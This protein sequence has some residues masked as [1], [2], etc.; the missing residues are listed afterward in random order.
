[1]P[2]TVLVFDSYYLDEA[3]WQGLWAKNVKIIGAVIPQRFTLINALVRRGVGMR[4]RWKALW[5]KKRKEL[6]VYVW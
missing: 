6:I 3:G 1:M 4:G 2:N 5:N